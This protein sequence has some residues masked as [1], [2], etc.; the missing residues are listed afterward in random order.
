MSRLKLSKRRTMKNRTNRRM[1]NRTNRRTNRRSNRKTNRRVKRRVNRRTNRRTRS[2]NSR[3]MYGGNDFMTL[4]E[5]EAYLAEKEIKYNSGDSAVAV[6]VAAANPPEDKR[7]GLTRDFYDIK[8]TGGPPFE[9]VHVLG[10]DR[11]KMTVENFTYSKYLELLG[12]VKI[13]DPDRYRMYEG[14]PNK[15]AHKHARDDLPKRIY[16]FTKLINAVLCNESQTCYRKKFMGYDKDTTR[17]VDMRFNKGSKDVACA[18]LGIRNDFFSGDTGISSPGTAGPGDTGISSP[19]TA[20]PLSGPAGSLSGPADSEQKPKT[21]IGPPPGATPP[22]GAPPP[23]P[24]GAPPPPPPG[25]PHKT[26]TSAPKL[27]K[28][29]GAKGA[30]KQ[31]FP[32]DDAEQSKIRQTLIRQGK[33]LGLRDD[34]GERSMPDTMT[35][36]KEHVPADKMEN[37]THAVFMYNHLYEQP[38]VKAYVNGGSSKITKDNTWQTPPV[39]DNTKIKVRDVED[40]GNKLDIDMTNIIA[41]YMITPQDVDTMSSAEKQGRWETIGIYDLLGWLVNEI[42]GSGDGPKQEATGEAARIE[43]ERTENRNYVCV[44]DNS[45]TFKEGEAGVDAGVQANNRGKTGKVT[46]SKTGSGKNWGRTETGS[47]ACNIKV[48]LDENGRSVFA[49]DSDV[50]PSSEV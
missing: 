13:A 45:V 42:K 10:G 29:K 7:R 4:E 46:Q 36:S 6:V 22:P 26:G 5:R 47:V 37:W 23:P 40:L 41:T 28:K 20:G 2:L 3:Q 12:E 16:K 15:P 9:G 39:Y 14:C 48:R 43:A 25:G 8:I 32:M 18:V 44:M 50:T 35:W 17:E 27:G 19:G 1:K 21:R 34:S 49:K 24:P 33:A 38:G 30:K 11:P 31:G